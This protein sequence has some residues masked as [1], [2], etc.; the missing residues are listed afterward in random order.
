MTN[1]IKDLNELSDLYLS[2]IA[3]QEETDNT[4]ENVKVRVMQI[5][6][7]IRY[8]AKKEGGNLVK[9]FNDYMGG[10]SGVG[11]A[12]RQMIKQRLGLQEEVGITTSEKMK[13]A[14]KDAEL[15]K[16]EAEA[17]KKAKVKEDSYSDWRDELR[18]VADDVPVTD[19][20]M[21]VKIKEKKVKN[22]IVINPPMQEEIKKM[23]GEILEM[24]EIEEQGS[25]VGLSPQEVTT[26]KRR[27]L[28]DIR[29]SR[30]R[31]KSLSKVK[32]EEEGEVK[33]EDY[34][35]KKKGEVLKAL[36]KKKFVKRYGKEKAPDVMYAVAAKTAKQKGDTSK[37][38]DRYAYEE[39]VHEVIDPKGARR[40]DA[41]KPKKE[42]PLTPEQKAKR[43]KANKQFDKE[44]YRPNP[45]EYPTM[46]K[47]RVDEEKKALPKIKMY[48][49]AG[50]LARKGDPESMKKQTKIV[51]T[52][53]KETSK[54]YKD[55]ALAKLRDGGSPKHQTQEDYK[56]LPVAKMAKKISD[57]SF[58]S[59]QSGVSTKSA[60]Q[61]GKMIGVLDTH[62]PQ[63]SKAKSKIKE[64]KKPGL[65]AN[66]HAR[67]KAGKPK[68]KPGDKNYPKTLD[69]EEDKA[70]HTVLGG[71]RK[72][73]KGGV[74]STQQDFDN[75]K[76]Q[77]ASQP[78]RKPEKDT[79][80][81]SQKMRDAVYGVSAANP[82]GFPL[83]T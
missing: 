77:N 57:K 25:M 80:S 36:D 70:F 44:Y 72:K 61:T 56:K 21:E 64:D 53:N 67:R 38:D 3:E 18:E 31:Q 4:P 69:I 5:V 37:S 46:W 8:K 33:T 42:T 68:R 71:L 7:A 15:Q 20:E 28:L 34:E 2:H 65:W 60:E 79:R 48:R 12:E 27:A 78:K 24:A 81:D 13:K 19:K 26:M 14:L 49:Q 76:K 50:N 23:G 39:V 54:G 47:K 45:Q 1:S 16:K 51:S 11:A 9:A 35:T 73:Y 63:R 29:L 74:L 58:K 62:D 52:L 22:K 40:Q 75:L 66:I 10:Q 6:K 83:R 82:K 43:D 17:I 59:G 41:A 30:L 55:A 32:P